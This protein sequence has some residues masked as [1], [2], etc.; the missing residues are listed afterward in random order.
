MAEVSLGDKARTTRAVSSGT[1]SS[2]RGSSD[3][4]VLAGTGA[5]QVDI[6]GHSL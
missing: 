4:P 6:V 5:S 3:I 1:P 2:D